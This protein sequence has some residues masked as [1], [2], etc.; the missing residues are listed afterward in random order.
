M[1]LHRSYPLWDLASYPGL[2]TELG[3]EATQELPSVGLAS[4]PGLRT[5][6]GNEATQE[7]PSMGPK[8]EGLTTSSQL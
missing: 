3:N 5:E 6:P 4:F 1:R 8:V 2:R 7:L